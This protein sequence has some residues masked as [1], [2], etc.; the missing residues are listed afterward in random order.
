M[1]FGAFVS[2]KSNVIGVAKVLVVSDQGS[3]GIIM[4]ADV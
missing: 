1:S 2:C 4:G 3:W